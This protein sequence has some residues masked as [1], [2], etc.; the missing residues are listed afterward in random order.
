[1]S[2]NIVPSRRG[3]I[4]RLRTIADYME[5]ANIIAKSGLAPKNFASAEAVFVAIL[6]GAELGL[7][8]M[9]ALYS[10][11]VING[12]PV[13]YGDALLALCMGHPDWD[14]SQF[15][16]TQIVG[17]RPEQRGW[18]CKVGRRGCKPVVREFT[19]A[20]AQQAGLLGKE[21]WRLYPQRMLQMRARSWALRDAFPDV[22]RGIGV[23]EE[24]VGVEIGGSWSVSG[25]SCVVGSPEV[26]DVADIGMPENA[27]KTVSNGLDDGGMNQSSQVSTLPQSEPGATETASQAV[28]RSENSG[29]EAAVGEVR[30]S[31]TLALK[32][33]LMKQNGGMHER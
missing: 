9:Q 2:A 8:P 3:Q 23:Y 28:S 24:W 15:E 1:M 12:R 27:S 20:D 7:S 6:S 22:L 11:A 13:L 4:V 17:A 25:Q 21:V 14:G 33:K 30:L 31:K 26:A 32:A 18:R 29:S 10:I 16:E 5:L 19:V